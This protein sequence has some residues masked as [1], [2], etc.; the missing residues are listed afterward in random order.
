MN[1]SIVIPVLNEKDNLE[2]L[3]PQL[4]VFGKMGADSSD[5]PLSFVENGLYEVLVCDNGSDDG[6]VEMA[7]NMGAR[8]LGPLAGEGR[9]VGH[10]VL[11]GIRAARFERIVIMDGDLSHPVEVAWRIATKLGER[12]LV[13]GSRY[14]DNGRSMD[15]RVN[16]VI[17]K[18]GNVLAFGLAPRLGD[19]MS[20]IWGMRVCVRDRVNGTARAT[21][22]PMLEYLV[23]G[24]PLGVGEVGYEF[25]PR[26]IGASKIGRKK[27]LGR[28]LKDLWHLYWVR[29]G[30]V[31]KFMM[32][33]GT[34][35]GINYGVT[36]GL[37]E[38]TGLWY[39]FSLLVGIGLAATWNFVLNDK[40]T[41]RD[42]H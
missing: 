24:K 8:V 27:I 40:W 20:G 6:T 3:I 16:R 30:R 19:R 29:F 18:T 11:R 33:G 23:R 22:K 15:K 26:E 32:V 39:G 5:R 13:V 12:E 35:I 41:W 7:R 25:R 37:T 21:A 14:R 1:T 9:T 42:R 36:V 34:G 10:A 17:S 28:S 4:R 2:K 31:P 38:G